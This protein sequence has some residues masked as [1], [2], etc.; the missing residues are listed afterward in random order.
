M[1][2]LP[3]ENLGQ[4]NHD[5]LKIKP[6]GYSDANH[7]GMNDL[8]S[9]ANG[10]GKNDVTNESETYPETGEPTEKEKSRQKQPKHADTLITIDYQVPLPDNPISRN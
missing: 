9:D 3:K 2:C 10:D 4:T 5:S 1:T 6:I 8:F 7:D